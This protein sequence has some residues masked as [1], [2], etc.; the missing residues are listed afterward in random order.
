MPPRALCGMLSIFSWC[1]MAWKGGEEGRSGAE[2]RR[3][4]VIHAFSFERFRQC[5]DHA[6]N[7]NCIRTYAC[8]LQY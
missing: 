8:S 6:C 5:Q 3:E 7:Y 4:H 2:K 1:R